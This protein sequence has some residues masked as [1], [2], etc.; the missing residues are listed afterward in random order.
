MNILVCMILGIVLVWMLSNL[1]M[2]YGYKIFGY[3]IV[4]CNMV[5]CFGI[6]AII[7]IYYLKYTKIYCLDAKLSC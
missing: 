7:L 4:I 6:T 2:I 5:I 3:F 1:F